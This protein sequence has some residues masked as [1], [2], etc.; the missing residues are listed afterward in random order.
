MRWTAERAIRAEPERVFRV[1]ADPEEFNRAIPDGREVE[2]LNEVRGGVGMQFR[3]WRMNRGKKMGFDQEVTEF[4]PGQRVRMVNVTHGTVWDG[5]FAVRR[6]GGGRDAVLTLT[7]DARTR[8]PLA[9]LMNRL[10]A[11]M[12]QRAL[13]KDLDAVKAY[14]ER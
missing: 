11:R 9:R 14:C 8:N 3:A 5:V 2:Y 4:V 7:M 12:V 13:E 1:M 10:I 6:E